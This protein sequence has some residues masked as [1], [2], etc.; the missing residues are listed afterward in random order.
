[1]GPPQ[2]VSDL[3]RFMVTHALSPTIDRNFDFVVAPVAYAYPKSARHFGQVVIDTSHDDEKHGPGASKTGLGKSDV[4]RHLHHCRMPRH[5]AAYKER[6]SHTIILYRNTP[7]PAYG[8][9]PSYPKRS[10]TIGRAKHRRGSS[11]AFAASFCAP[12][13]N[14][15]MPAIL[16]QDKGISVFESETRPYYLAKNSGQIRPTGLTVRERGPKMAYN[17][18]DPCGTFYGRTVPRTHHEPPRVH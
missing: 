15:S 9:T 3:H 13:P 11:G 12:S 6:I 1:M 16:D 8:R 17:Q 4:P 10:S 2:H 7:R 14:A 5:Q 18:G